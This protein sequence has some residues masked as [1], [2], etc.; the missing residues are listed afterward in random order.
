MIAILLHKI[1]LLKKLRKATKN[2]FSISEFSEH[3]NMKNWTNL[4][5]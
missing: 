4:S 2:S 3:E 1:S 5:E